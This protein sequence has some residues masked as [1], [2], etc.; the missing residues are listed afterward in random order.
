MYHFRMR[1]QEILNKWAPFLQKNLD[2]LQWIMEGTDSLI[3]IPLNDGERPVLFFFFLFG[4]IVSVSK[5][6]LSFI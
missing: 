6:S 4:R 1:S 5:S 2:I 3:Y